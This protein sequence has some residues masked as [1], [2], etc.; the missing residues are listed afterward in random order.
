MKFSGGRWRW[1]GVRRRESAE[2]DLEMRS[3]RVCD[4]RELETIDFSSSFDEGR[5]PFDSG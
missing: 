4:R 5:G 2:R 3:F 1:R